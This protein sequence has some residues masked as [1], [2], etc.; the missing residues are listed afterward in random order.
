MSLMSCRDV[1]MSLM[2]QKSTRKTRYIEPLLCECWP[3]SVTLAP[4]LIQHEIILGEEAS[5][6]R[7]LPAN[8]KHLSKAALM[9]TQHCC[10]LCCDVGCVVI[11]RVTW[12]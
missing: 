9:L 10:E 8:T 6:R 3:T 2:P 1:V 4:T 7:V 11:L 12:C 5:L